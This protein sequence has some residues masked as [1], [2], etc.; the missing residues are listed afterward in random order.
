MSHVYAV[1]RKIGILSLVLLS[2]MVVPGTTQAEYADV[3]INRQAE[4]NGMRPV[5]FPH[6]FHRIR[7]RCKV[8]HAELGFKMRAGSNTIT[9][10]DI[11]EG[12]F[13]GACHNNDIAWSPE[14]CDL[15]HSGKPGLPTGVFGGHETS[16]PGRW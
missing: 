3:V 12:K 16:G 7:F 15:C 10:T 5:V 4:K 11:I 9:M 14:N 13:C 1:L 6:W 8:C 2:L